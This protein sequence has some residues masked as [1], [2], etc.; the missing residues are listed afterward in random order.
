MPEGAGRF[1]LGGFSGGEDDHAD[2]EGIDSA[3]GESEEEGGG[4]DEENDGVNKAG[5]AGGAAVI[6]VGEPGGEKSGSEQEI[7]HELGFDGKAVGVRKT[8]HLSGATVAHQSAFLGKTGE[9]EAGLEPTPGAD[10]KSGGEKYAP[11]KGDEAAGNDNAFRGGL[12]SFGGLSEE[13]EFFYEGRIKDN[14]FE[15]EKTEDGED[16]KPDNTGSEKTS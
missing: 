1:D 2:D 13:A 10:E 15:A 16:D 11:E 7:A 14:I 5:I 8:E 3:A 6:R 12:G 9:I 4:E